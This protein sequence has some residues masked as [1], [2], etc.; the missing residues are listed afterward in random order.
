MQY[1]LKVAC[2]YCESDEASGFICSECEVY[3]C[4]ECFSRGEFHEAICI[5]CSQN[6]SESAENDFQIRIVAPFAGTFGNRI[7]HVYGDSLES[8][9]QNALQMIRTLLPRQNSTEVVIRIGE[10]PLRGKGAVKG[11]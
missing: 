2:F 9:F 6:K 5:E 7:L 11:S 10:A 8:T 1:Q 3:K 4:E